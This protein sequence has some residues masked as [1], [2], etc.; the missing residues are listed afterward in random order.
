MRP[1]YDRMLDNLTSSYL[2]ATESDDFFKQLKLA[3]DTA[4]IRLLK[5]GLSLREVAGLDA[6]QIKRLSAAKLKANGTASHCIE[7]ARDRPVR[8]S[9]DTATVK[10]L[11]NSMVKCGKE[12]GKV[13]GKVPVLTVRGSLRRI[14]FAKYFSTSA[15]N[16]ET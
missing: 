5:L 10:S 16:D 15:V 6:G 2:E 14:F 3:R 11:V 13:G 1:D 9:L 4:I 7:L 8:V 12:A